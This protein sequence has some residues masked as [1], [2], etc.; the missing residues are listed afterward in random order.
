MIVLK[1]SLSLSLSVCVV[2][3]ESVDVHISIQYIY[4]NNFCISVQ[5][6]ATTHSEHIKGAHLLPPTVVNLYNGQ[7]V[8]AS[9]GPNNLDEQIQIT[10]VTGMN[11]N[12]T[13]KKA[14]IVYCAYQVLPANIFFLFC[15]LLSSFFGQHLGLH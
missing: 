12:S 7:M 6:N 5:I 8:T 1:V 9:I 3:I 15:C 14:W 4:I 13:A 11:Q 10:R 2:N